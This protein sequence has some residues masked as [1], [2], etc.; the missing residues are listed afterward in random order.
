MN[1]LVTGGTGFIGSHIVRVLQRE[2]HRVAVTGTPSCGEQ[3]PK[4]VKVFPHGLIGVNWGGLYRYMDNK[5]DVLFHQAA[6]ND[7]TWDD[8]D[9]MEFDNVE[10]SLGVFDKCAYLGCRK[11]VYASSTAIYGNAPAPQKED[12]R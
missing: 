11:I 3:F 2:G 10:S 7:T 5:I 8:D 4:G 6:N 12:G 9:E 1:I